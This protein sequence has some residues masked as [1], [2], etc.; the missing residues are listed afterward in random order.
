[1]QMM[2]HW[3]LVYDEKWRWVFYA[4]FRPGYY[5]MMKEKSLDEQKTGW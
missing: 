1:M 5:S 4:A 2:M 3:W